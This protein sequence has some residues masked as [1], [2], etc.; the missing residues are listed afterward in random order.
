MMEL[1]RFSSFSILVLR[2]LGSHD[3]DLVAVLQL[4]V[5]VI[6]I[7]TGLVFAEPGEARWLEY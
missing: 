5:E 3:A 7:R 2:H 1:L 4:Y 6:E